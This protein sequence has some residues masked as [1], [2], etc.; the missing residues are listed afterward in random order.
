MTDRTPRKLEFKQE[1][2]SRPRSLFQ[3]ESTR[4][5]N[6][7]VDSSLSYVH[8]NLPNKF[9][10]LEITK[11]RNRV[12][13]FYPVNI[14]FVSDFAQDLANECSEITLKA[15]TFLRSFQSL[16]VDQKI[17]DCIDSLGKKSLMERMGLTQPTDH[18]DLLS[19]EKLNLKALGKN[20]EIILEKIK[21][22][23]EELNICLISLTCVDKYLG[24]EKDSNMDSVF[25]NRQIL[26]IQLGQQVNLLL[27]QIE[28]AS[29]VISKHISNI[30]NFINVTYPAM[31]MKNK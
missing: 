20:F 27:I 1:S 16:T 6:Y 18:I 2:D 25:Y 24:D 26:F 12:A 15:S 3:D 5:R 7:F 21:E 22:N 30:D 19:K 9:S 17:K 23:E 13:S 28:Q 29:G 14:N 8:N 10:S 4:V 31:K 11:I